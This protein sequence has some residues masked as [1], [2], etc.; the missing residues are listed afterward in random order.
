[1]L[2]DGVNYIADSRFRDLDEFKIQIAEINP[3][4]FTRLAGAM[5]TVVSNALKLR[6][7][8][9]ELGRL[10]DHLK[11]VYKASAKFKQTF[12]LGSITTNAIDRAHSWLE[13]VMNKGQGSSNNS[14]DNNDK[15]L[16]YISNY[17]QDGNDITRKMLNLLDKWETEGILIREPEDEDDKKKKP[18]PAP[19]S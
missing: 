3:D 15:N 14:T 17:L 12:E 1:M 19:A 10:S 16:S 13:G 9:N 4:P 6:T 11:D 2:R 5:D 18:K 8:N 7:I